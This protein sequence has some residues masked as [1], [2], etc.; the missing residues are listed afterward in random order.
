MNLSNVI[1]VVT[2]VSQEVSLLNVMHATEI[3]WSQI[4]QLNYHVATIY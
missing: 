3:S 2:N 1:F 4:S